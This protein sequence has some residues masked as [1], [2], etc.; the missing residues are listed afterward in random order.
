MNIKVD[1]KAIIYLYVGCGNHRIKGFTHVEINPGKK[2]KKGDNVGHPD[3]MA[4]ITER[5][6]LP[7]GSVSLIFSRATLEHLTYR[8]LINHFLECHRLLKKNGV[9]RM[10]VPDLSAI[11]QNYLDKKMTPPESRGDINPDFPCKNYVDDFIRRLLYF[12]HYY[13]HN[14]DT[15]N[16]AL[17][18]TG[19]SNARRCQPGDSIIERANKVLCEAEIGRIENGEIIVEAQKLDLVPSIERY[20]KELPDRFILKILAK[21]F[22]IRIVPYVKRRPVFPQILWFYEK[23]IKR[24]ANIVDARKLL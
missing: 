14:F 17:I 11:V 6:P 21:L 2:F 8:E 7:S 9:V 16:R 3:I 12:D 10:V 13:L 5:I 24:K 15:L 4:D 19:F 18:K 23:F 22:N 1:P 20:K